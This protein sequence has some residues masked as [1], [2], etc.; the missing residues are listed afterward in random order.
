[1]KLTARIVLIVL[2]FTAAFPAKLIMAQDG[3]EL[4]EE[5]VSIGKSVTFNYPSGWVVEESI[6]GFILLA[7]DEETIDEPPS[8]DSAL[9]TIFDPSIIGLFVDDFEPTSLDE[10][11][12][13][14]IAGIEDLDSTYGEVE[15]TSFGDHPAIQRSMI[16]EGQEGT[17][18][19]IEFDEDYVLVLASS[20][21]GA[22][23][24]HADKVNAIL[25]TLSYDVPEEPQTFTSEDETLTLEYPS[26]WRIF[27][28]MGMIMISN[29]TYVMSDDTYETVET[30]L[31][32]MI[33]IWIS[34]PGVRTTQTDFLINTM[35]GY[36][37]LTL[38]GAEQW[39]QGVET[40]LGEFDA[41]RLDFVNKLG[42]GYLL[43]VDVGAEDYMYIMV[44]TATGELAD[45][46]EDEPP[47]WNPSNIQQNK[48]Q[49]G[50]AHHSPAHLH[51]SACV[52]CGELFST[53]RV[54]SDALPTWWKVF[55]TWLR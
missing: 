41:A 45:F 23:E 37:S 17:A 29:D 47:F 4:T 14:L 49:N 11:M 31:P 42:E 28:N 35:L 48:Q 13:I 19:F 26:G 25:D 44:F 50:A 10:A 40:T 3:D 43:A 5:Y 46:E 34:P 36:P 33:R 21:A 54:P 2:L 55:H 22:Y 20:A 7:S 30:L 38:Y 52:L 1:M 12:E 8:G 16:T 6:P 27:E 39:P 53:R 15:E 51:S 9:L 24:D 32:G 18:T